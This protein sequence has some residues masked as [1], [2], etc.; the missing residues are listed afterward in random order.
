MTGKGALILLFEH[1][2]AMENPKVKFG[3]LTSHDLFFT[4]SYDFCSKNMNMGLFQIGS[5]HYRNLTRAMHDRV[6]SWS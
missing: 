6:M 5:T 2:C 1:R 3:N 4:F